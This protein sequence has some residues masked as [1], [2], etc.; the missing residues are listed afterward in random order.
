MTK[1]KIEDIRIRTTKQDGTALLT[2]KGDP[3]FNVGIK[4]EGYEKWM[5]CNIFGERP[6]WKQGDEIEVASISEREYN[7]KTYL[8]YEMP[9]KSAANLGPVKDQLDRIEGLLKTLVARAEVA[10]KEVNVD[11]DLE[12]DDVF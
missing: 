3:Y 5:S 7:G 4:A 8:N 11:A 12:P 10:D 2:K 6:T 1:I 9:K